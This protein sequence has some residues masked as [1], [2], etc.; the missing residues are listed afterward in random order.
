MHDGILALEQRIDV[1]RQA[2]IGKTQR[3][4]QTTDKA[5]VG[6]QHV[7][8]SLHELRAHHRA[9]LTSRTCYQDFHETQ[10]V[11]TQSLTLITARKTGEFT[12]LNLSVPAL[13]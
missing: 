2:Q 8:S 6:G 9:E 4:R 1:G 7:V 3:R 13:A 10:P 5:L 11:L 12:D